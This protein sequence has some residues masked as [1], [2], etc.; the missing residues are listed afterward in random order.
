MY[1]YIAEYANL[2]PI[3]VHVHTY[4][5]LQATSRSMRQAGP[6]ALAVCLMHHVNNHFQKVPLLRASFLPPVLHYHLTFTHSAHLPSPE[7]RTSPWLLRPA[8]PHV[9]QVRPEPNPQHGLIH[10]GLRT[11]PGTK[12]QRPNREDKLWAVSGLTLSPM[13]FEA[14]TV[15]RYY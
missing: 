12:P 1:F 2:I 7:A 6:G 13:P 10:R 15:T 9:L 4:S 3:K 5:P 8:F 11:L 14:V